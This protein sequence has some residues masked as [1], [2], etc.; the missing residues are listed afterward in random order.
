MFILMK[1]LPFKS[2]E[3]IVLNEIHILKSAWIH[4]IEIKV[5]VYY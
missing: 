4:Y 1:R 2:L 3:S 5:T